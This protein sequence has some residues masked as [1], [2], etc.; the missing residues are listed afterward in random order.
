MRIEWQRGGLK[1][2]NAHGNTHHSV[3]LE[4]KLY[5]TLHGFGTD[6]LFIGQPIVIDKFYE[7][8]GTVS[9]LFNFSSVGV[10]NT[11]FKVGFAGVSRL[12]D[13]NLI[14]ADSEMPIG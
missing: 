12:H 3:P 8:A 5:D 1:G 11:I 13:Q 10:K 9:A 6:A 4:F 14:G 2:R 7:T